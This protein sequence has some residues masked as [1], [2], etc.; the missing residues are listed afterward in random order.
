MP[1]LKLLKGIGSI[2]FAL[3]NNL[4]HVCLVLFFLPIIGQLTYYRHVDSTGT[5]HTRMMVHTQTSTTTAP[6]TTP[7]VII[8]SMDITSALQVC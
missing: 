5:V 3:H 1:E 6:P 4:T 7:V 8:S 2:K